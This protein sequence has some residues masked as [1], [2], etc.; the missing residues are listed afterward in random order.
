MVLGF[1]VVIAMPLSGSVV[2]L[3]YT[4]ELKSHRTA[5]TIATNMALDDIS[6]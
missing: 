1:I 6:V 3:L 5:C 2:P 4:S